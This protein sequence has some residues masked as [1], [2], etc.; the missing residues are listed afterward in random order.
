MLSHSLQK[1]TYN[2][3]INYT[4]DAV[5]ITCADPEGKF[6]LTSPIKVGLPMTLTIQSENWDY[7][8]Q[9]FQ[10]ACGTFFIHEIT[11]DISKTGGSIVTIQATTTPLTPQT[12]I[13]HERKSKGQDSTTLK[14]LSQQIAT[15]NG[16][17]LKY[18][19]PK[20]PTIGRN[21]Q[22]DQS[23]LVHL[24]THCH[25]NDLCLKIKDKTL[26]IQSHEQLEKAGPVGIIV[27]P[28]PGNPGGINSAGIINCRLEENLED[29]FAGAE[30]AY[31]DNKTG[32][33]IRGNQ[34]DPTTS[35][36]VGH[37]HRHKHNPHDQENTNL[38]TNPIYNAPTAAASDSIQS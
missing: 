31:K 7:P 36:L 19:A 10:R 32:Q 6:R 13:R 20:D 34:I 17:S 30:V 29:V 25:E 3:N 37:V 21:D 12:S 23:D 35:K 18:L 28:T 22:H 24:G 16:L 33:V 9:I 38:N 26:W 1:L 5:S 27:C 11:F 14:A 15:T 8:G 4:S 2:E